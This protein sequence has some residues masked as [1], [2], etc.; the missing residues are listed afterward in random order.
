VRTISTDVT[1]ELLVRKESHPG[2][3]GGFGRKGGEKEEPRGSD[4]GQNHGYRS[5][6]TRK[7]M[8]SIQI[9]EF[10]E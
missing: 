1:E 2:S 4:E 5:K 7:I 9:D 8:I 10:S 3:D 6:M